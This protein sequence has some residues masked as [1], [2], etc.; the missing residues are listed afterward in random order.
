MADPRAL[1]SAAVLDHG[2]RPRN[3]RLPASAT[4]RAEGYN[5]GC[6]DR[7]VVGV[8]LDGERLG[9]VGFEASGCA[10]CVA[11][12]SV[13]TEAVKGSQRSAAIDRARRFCA[14]VRGEDDAT[15]TDADLAGLVAFRE[16]GRYPV[17]IA[18]ATLAW[19]A[20]HDALS[21]A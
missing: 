18:C 1:Y 8:T 11:S 20:L 12:A 17:R 3:A 7:L 16:V 19:T 2:K 5:A 10:I 13:M 21:A 6:G 9:D 4:R 14:M 15:R